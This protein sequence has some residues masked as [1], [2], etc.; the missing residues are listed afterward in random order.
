[1]PELAKEQNS[2]TSFTLAERLAKRILRQGPITFRDWMECALYDTAQGYY[3]RND[4][5]RWGREGDY[6]T[7]PQRTELFAA[8]FARYFAE[9]YQN[10][11]EPVEWTITECGAGD[12]TFAYGVL[13]ALQDTFPDVFQ[14]TRFVVDEISVVSQ[15]VLAQRLRGF[16]DRV[17]FSSLTS[18]DSIDVG[19]VFSNE[20]F[21]AF[22][23][24]LLT[25]A[26][27]RLQELYVTATESGKF[28]FVFQD[29]STPKLAEFC[30]RH[31]IEPAEG[32]TIEINLGIDDWLTA[33]SAKFK[34]G[35]L[36]TV[37]YGAEAEELHSRTHGTLRAYSRHRFVDDVLTSPG[38]YDI[39]SSVNWSQVRTTSARLGFEVIEFAQQDKFLLR[40]GLLEELQRRL[41]ETSSEADRLQLTTT[42]RQMILPGGMASSFQVLVQARTND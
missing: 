24:H 33:L 3:M 38:E 13:T 7:S 1:M 2:P 41:E 11:H 30:I 29:A 15:G 36:I 35:Y 34:R 26:R 4:L 28:E 18:L 27:G 9:L 31:K 12:G 10:L 37:D 8:A 32:Q 22:P 17:R 14:A 39:T 40:S 42:A 5:T 21:D 25:L 23:V 16:G 6:L 19:V 20:L